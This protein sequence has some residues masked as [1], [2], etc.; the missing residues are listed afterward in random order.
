M[1]VVYTFKDKLACGASVSQHCAAGFQV[2]PQVPAEDRVQET[3]RQTQ[4][5]SGSDN[6]TGTAN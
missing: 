1:I 4:K 5:P 6:Q 2:L 3:V